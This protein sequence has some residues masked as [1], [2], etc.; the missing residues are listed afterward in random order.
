MPLVKLDATSSTNDFLKQLAK[1]Q[2]LENFTVVTAENQTNGKGQMGTS[3][4]SQPGKNLIFSVLMINPV[5]D[6]S[7]LFDIN[8]YVSMAVFSTLVRLKIPQISI[9]W[10]NDIMSGNKKIG[11]ILI[12]NSIRA[13]GEIVSIA[14]IGLNV[15][16][17]DFERLPNATSLL[18]LCKR[19]FDRD[20][21]LNSIID[22]LRLNV[23]STHIESSVLWN[24][25]NQSIFKNGKPTTFQDRSGR[26]FMAVITHVGND[27]LLNVK[28]EDGTSKAFNIKEIKMLY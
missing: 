12:E 8:I 13:N 5:S 9:K 27:G 14:G 19:E 23:Q 24:Q 15:N 20:V 21:L 25:Y 1:K 26:P 11:G 6:L 22:T 10:P 2:S 7:K 18:N 3:W 17:S 4:E 16:Q 28:L